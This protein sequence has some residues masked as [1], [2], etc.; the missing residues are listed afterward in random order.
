MLLK[1]QH[2]QEK[3]DGRP[4]GL[5][6]KADH[7]RG[8]GAGGRRFGSGPAAISLVTSGHVLSLSSISPSPLFLANPR[9]PLGTGQRCAVMVMRSKQTQSILPAFQN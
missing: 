6:G 7:T 3:A 9:S 5:D 2:F 8:T 4:G 1:I